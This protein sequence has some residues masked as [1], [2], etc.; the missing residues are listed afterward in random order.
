MLFSI[1]TK[2][3]SVVVK[4]GFPGL[5]NWQAFWTKKGYR[6][7]I[8]PKQPPF[9][10]VQAVDYWTATTGAT[11]TSRVW[12]VYFY[13]GGLGE[14]YKTGTGYGLCMECARWIWI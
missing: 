8:S 10:N 1:L 13:I 7:S 6:W 14:G 3:L 9:T 4:G 11:S 2:R 12:L 5:K